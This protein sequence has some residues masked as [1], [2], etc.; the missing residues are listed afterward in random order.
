L[1]LEDEADA[2]HVEVGLDQVAA[3][4]GFVTLPFGAHAQPLREVPAYADAVGEIGGV[5]VD[6]VA[7]EGALVAAE[8]AVDGEPLGEMEGPDRDELER[9]GLECGGA[10]GGLAEVVVAKL[11]REELVELEA[12]QS[13][14]SLRSQ[15]TLMT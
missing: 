8:L 1:E 2:Q 15:S 7:F 3:A 5:L 6:A 12:A 11:D 10:R 9:F 4:Q 13:L 14:R